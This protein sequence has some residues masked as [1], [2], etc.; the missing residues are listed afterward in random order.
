M[1]VVTQ[2]EDYSWYGDER[3]GRSRNYKHN[4]S[5][6][7]QTSKT[8]NDDNNYDMATFA[9]IICVILSI[10]NYTITK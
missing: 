10:L 2:H 7:T 9:A 8:T 5:V 6:S 3:I 4:T 1:K